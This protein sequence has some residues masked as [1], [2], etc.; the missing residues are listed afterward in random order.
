MSDSPLRS[1][2]PVAL[3]T[4]GAQRIGR[5]IAKTLHQRG[6][7]ILIH[8]RRST[9]AAEELAGE[10][11]NQRADSA[12]IL[13]ADFAQSGAAETLA[14]AAINTFGRVDALINNAS[15]FY[16]TPVGRITEQDFDGLMA[17]NLRAPLFLSQALASE[18]AARN[19][20]IVN[21]VDIYAQRPLAEHTAY[22]CAKAGVAML[23]QSL[24]LELAPAVR[25]NGVAP[26]AIL[27]P[28]EES[29]FVSQEKLNIE[30]RV[31]LR[32]IGEPDDIARTIAF[33]VC[34][35]PYI[36]GQILAVDGG[37]TLS[38]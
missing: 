18:L 17:S 28:T 35:A 10:L 27:M 1:E 4:G 31:A 8:Y 36:T 13:S 26:G 7:R 23:T 33:L 3:I 34:D 21:L 11:N 2:S 15:D 5:Q 30:Q 14:Q 24:A 6:Y 19:G 16:P 32:R 22:C 29:A 9:D 12:A 38:Q 25:V 20:C 37:R